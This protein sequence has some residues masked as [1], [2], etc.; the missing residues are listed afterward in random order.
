MHIARERGKIRY[1]RSPEQGLMNPRTSSHSS[2]AR[3]CPFLEDSLPRGNSTP[4]LD[5]RPV[6]IFLKGEP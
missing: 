5:E 2:V 1:P 3:I 4:M 6:L